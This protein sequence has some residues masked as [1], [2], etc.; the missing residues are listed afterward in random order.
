MQAE[1][2]R[3]DERKDD[4]CEPVCIL[5]VLLGFWFDEQGYMHP[6]LDWYGV[7]LIINRTDLWAR[8]GLDWIV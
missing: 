1:W 6:Q 2:A 4:F 8:D 3:E 5:R 7:G